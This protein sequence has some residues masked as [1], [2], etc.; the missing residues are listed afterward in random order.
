MKRTATLVAGL[1][2]VTGTVFAGTIDLSG[3]SIKFSSNV[4]STQGYNFD[5]GNDGD[6]D[7]V[8]K[9]NY[10]IDPTTTVSFKYETDS[11][12]DDGMSVIMNKKVGAVEGQWAGVLGSKG[13]Q[14][15]FGLLED[16]NSDTYIKWTKSPALSLTFFPYAFNMNNGTLFD[17]DGH[18][19]K[20][21][22]IVANFKNGYVGAG[23][24]AVTAEKQV[25]GLKAGYTVKAGA[26]SVT[27]KY[28]G[29]FFDKDVVGQSSLVGPG[30]A[31]IKEITQDVNVYAEMT[32]GKLTFKGEVGYNQLVKDTYKYAGTNDYV[33]NGFGAIAKVIYQ[34]SPVLSPYALVKHRTDG[35][36]AGDIETTALGATTAAV[37]KGGI[38]T[39]VIGAD[40]KLTPQLNFNAEAELNVAGEKIYADS[41]GASGKE[42]T[43]ASLN[44]SVSYGF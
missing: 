10:T 33:N 21:P 39:G 5:G 41:K 30:D 8:L 24:D 4:F 14:Q 42:K 16:K 32:Q 6:T 11:T 43:A 34:A 37:K 25:V 44:L 19:S 38:T 22:G 26:L 20:V 2:L 15:Q 23:I 1:L 36:L 40:Y 7:G 18:H 35:F 17:D 31:T 9:L 29:V 27:A 28:S 3:T 13:A 12:F